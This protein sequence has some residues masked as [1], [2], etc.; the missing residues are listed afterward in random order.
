MARASEAGEMPEM[1]AWIALRATPN[2]FRWMALSRETRLVMITASPRSSGADPDEGDLLPLTPRGEGSA[3][4]VTQQL[5]M[6][7]ALQLYNDPS[8]PVWLRQVMIQQQ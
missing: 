8:L 5:S 6:T 1:L 7:Q 4:V 3:S 2:R